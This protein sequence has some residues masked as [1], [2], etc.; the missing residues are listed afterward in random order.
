MPNKN[1]KILRS[2]VKLSNKG[3]KMIQIG[4][5]LEKIMTNTIHL[6]FGIK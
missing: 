3:F 1:S 2:S 4:G 5:G 6:I